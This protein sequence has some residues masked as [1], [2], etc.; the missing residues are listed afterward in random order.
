MLIIGL[1]Y[2]PNSAGYLLASVFG[3]RWI[4]KIM[5]REARKA[6]RYD[7]KGRLEL[8]PEDRMQENAW[9][10]AILWPASL[11]W[12]G[13]TAEKGVLWICPMIANC[14]LT[15]LSFVSLVLTRHSFLR[16]WLN[17]DLLAGL[18][19]ADRVHAKACCI[20]HCS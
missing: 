19:H 17:A 9:M 1:L 5:H 11:I 13:W 14:K 18:D 3:G 15:N 2:I 4:D 6:G 8:R 10:A 20:W 16:R 12:Y 7:E